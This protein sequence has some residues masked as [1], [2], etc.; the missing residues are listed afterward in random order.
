MVSEGRPSVCRLDVDLETLPCAVP[1]H[2]I[3]FIVFPIHYVIFEGVVFFVNQYSSSSG[4]ATSLESF[5][6]VGPA[7]KMHASR[8]MAVG[9][10][11]VLP[12]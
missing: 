6:A 5:F 8:V 10:F 2:T 3:V 9:C 12:P 4:V 11:T 1:I 7:I